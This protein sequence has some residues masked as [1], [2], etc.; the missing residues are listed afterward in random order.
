MVRTCS[1]SPLFQHFYSNK[2]KKKETICH[3]ISNVFY[4][5]KIKRICRSVWWRRQ[6]LT[7]FK[8]ARFHNKC[9][10]LFDKTIMLKEN[11]I[12]SVKR[13]N[14]CEPQ[15]QISLKGTLANNNTLIYVY[16]SCFD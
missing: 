3:N 16:I 14:I 1:L 8:R 11:Q 5:H 2:S 6:A 4:I 9:E 7:L 15:P 12:P 10:N 13:F